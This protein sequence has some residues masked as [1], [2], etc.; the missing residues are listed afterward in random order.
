MITVIIPVKNGAACIQDCL[1]GVLSQQS[2][3]NDYEIIVVDDGSVD[4]TKKIAEDMGVRV[5][6]QVNAGPASARNTGAKA[7]AGDILAF[8]DADC[9]PTPYW[10][11]H[12]T[13]PFHDPEIVGTKGTYRTLQKSLV[14]RFVQQE[15]ESKYEQMRHQK[16]ID[17]IDTYSAAYRKNVFFNN[18]G[19]DPALPILEDQELS[20]RLARKGYQMVFCPNATVYHL[21]NNTVLKYFL[22]KFWIG[23]WKAFMLRWLPEKAVSDSHTLPSQRWQILFLCLAIAS[24]LL[25]FISIIAWWLALITLGIFLLTSLPFLNQIRQRDVPVL[26]FALPLLLIRALAQALGL[27]VGFLFPPRAQQRRTTGLDLPSRSLKRTLDVVG[28]LACAIL[29]LPIILVC[30]IAVKLE[31]GGPVCFKQE[32]AGENGRPFCVIKLRTMVI[33]AENE[34]KQI[35]K[36]NPLRGPVFKIP[37]DP[38]VTR[39]GRFLRR[40][41]LDEL[42]Q[43]WN[44]L[45]GEMSLVGPRPEETWIVAQYNDGQRQ[46]LAVKPGITGPMQVSGRGELGM[47]ERLTL[48]LDYIN[49]YSLWKDVALLIRTL[50]AVF[51]GKGAF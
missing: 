5:I 20:F 49:H 29:S 50:P 3:D 6:S 7:A 2:L 30:A 10:L 26:I 4:N 15:Y 25:G 39:V 19:F 31:D 51:R 34:V 21:H 35:L 48:E 24:L 36:N 46:R 23:Y 41:S 47:D 17:F 14:A 27:A 38:R 9:S 18:S 22:R 16:N 11:K 12:L 40:W 44:V 37:D 1:R 33:G 13:A 43:F 8:T 42:P 28:G 45:R 32:R